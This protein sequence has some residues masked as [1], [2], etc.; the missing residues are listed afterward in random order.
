MKVVQIKL[1]NQKSTLI[2]WVDYRDDLKIGNFI[3][4]KEFKRGIRWRIEE[5]YPGVHEADEFDWHRK[6]SN[7]I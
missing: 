6:W 1:R 7:N 4:L 2:T 5:I 3:T